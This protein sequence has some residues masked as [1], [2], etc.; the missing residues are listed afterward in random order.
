MSDVS[1]TFVGH[2]IA[3]KINLPPKPITSQKWRR[4]SIQ[5]ISYHILNHSRPLLPLNFNENIAIMM[6]EEFTLVGSTEFECSS[7][8]E[9]NDMNVDRIAVMLEQEQTHYSPCYDYTSALKNN[10]DGI[11]EN[12]RQKI[13]EWVF[14]VVDLLKFDREVV[15]ITL[16]YLDRVIAHATETSKTMCHTK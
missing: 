13:A 8:E 4:K 5:A 11:N 6:A 3:F 10:T 2:C 12:W 15:S 1:A 7:C 9:N 14:K 16:N